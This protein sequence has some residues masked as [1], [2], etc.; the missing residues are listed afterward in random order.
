MTCI[1]ALEDNGKIYM[2]ADSA[3]VDGEAI[4]LRKEPKIFKC[5][6]FLIGFSHSFRYGQIVEHCFKPPKVTEKN[7]V[8]YMV[9]EFVPELRITLAMNE[10]EEK[11]SCMIIG[12]RG[13][14]FYVESDWNVGYDE[15]NYHSIGSGAPAAFGSL[16]STKG[17]HPLDRVR[18][19]LEAAQEFTTSV[20]GPF[21]YLDI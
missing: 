13:K 20:R 3:A 18:V 10:F 7:I 9:T 17:Q 1:V 5:G 12:H 14:I 21:N 2:G 16:Y 15:T 8:K 11:E 6:E 19:A 4:S